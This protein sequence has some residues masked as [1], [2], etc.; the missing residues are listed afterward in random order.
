MAHLDA[1]H[2]LVVAV[3]PHHLVGGQLLEADAELWR[4][5]RG[6]EEEAWGGALAV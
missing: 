2:E 6:E 4:E 1:H 5:E 3:D